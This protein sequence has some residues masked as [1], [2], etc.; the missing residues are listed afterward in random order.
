MKWAERKV[1][2]VEVSKKG[3]RTETTRKVLGLDTGFI[4]LIDVASTCGPERVGFCQRHEFWF[5][6]LERFCFQFFSLLSQFSLPVILY[7]EFDSVAKDSLDWWSLE[8]E[9]W[10]GEVV[11][12][13]KSFD[14]LEPRWAR[15]G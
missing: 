10:M 1:L 7:I 9:E 11:L 15:I 8:E 13:A 3:V 14:G 4:Q 5:E 2:F 12:E 6:K